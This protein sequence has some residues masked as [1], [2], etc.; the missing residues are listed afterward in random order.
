MTNLLEGAEVIA[1]PAPKNQDSYWSAKN[2]IENLETRSPR[3]DINAVTFW[4]GVQSSAGTQ[5]VTTSTK[6]SCFVT[7]DEELDA[8]NDLFVLTIDLKAK[9]LV[10]GFLLTEDTFNSNA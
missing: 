2:L 7:T 4:D 8:D 6:S 9:Y 1:A 5:I 10:D 3:S